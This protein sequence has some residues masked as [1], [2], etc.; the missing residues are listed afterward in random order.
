MFLLNSYFSPESSSQKNSNVPDSIILNGILPVATFP[1]PSLAKI[2]KRYSP[3]SLTVKLTVLLFV[4][5][6]LK[7]PFIGFGAFVEEEVSFKVFSAFKVS[8][9]P[10]PSQAPFVSNVCA[11]CTFRIGCRG[12]EEVMSGGLLAS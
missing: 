2:N 6:F 10:H 1:F 5:A 8:P 3:G 11:L 9:S 12:E 7:I 4:S